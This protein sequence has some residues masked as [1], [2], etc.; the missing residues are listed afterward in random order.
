M[1][2]PFLVNLYRFHEYREIGFLEG[3]TDFFDIFENF[4]LENMKNGE[5]LL[6][7]QQKVLY[8]YKKL[9]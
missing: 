8:M 6:S 3:N 4:P 5:K 7:V 2:F 1:K 9:I